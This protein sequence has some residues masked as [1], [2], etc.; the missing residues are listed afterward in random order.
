MSEIS[1]LPS[2]LP[3]RANTGV[4]PP[5]LRV[6]Y[7]RAAL[8]EADMRSDP[9]E[10]FGVWFAQARA[11]GVA[12]ANAMTLATVGADGSPSAR[13]VLLKEF[14]ARGFTFHTNYD[15]RKG[16]ELEA[17]PRAA[18]CFHWQP[19]ERQ[20]RIEGFVERASRAESEAY[21]RTRPVAAQIGAWV[22]HQSTPIASRAELEK[23]QH[24]L[25]KR[26]SDGPVPLPPYWGGLRVVPHAIEFWQGR[27]SR[28]H[29]RILYIR[30]AD[31]AWMRQRL[32]P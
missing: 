9:L 6:D 15:S 24:E 25:T 13:I 8:D 26:F 17:N 29:D 30:Q 28:L 10:Q 18:L 3:P 1:P 32:S 5:E 23:L 22:S 20:V 14:D 12:E 4:V 7:G 31:G 27:P 11:A 19:L 2:S 21:F 16:R